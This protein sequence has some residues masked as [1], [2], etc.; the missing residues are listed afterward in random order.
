MPPLSAWSRESCAGEPPTGWRWDCSLAPAQRVYLPAWQPQH[1]WDF[2]EMWHVKC[3]SFQKVWTFQAVLL[4]L[5][6]KCCLLI[7]TCA[8]QQRCSQTPGELI[9]GLQV[10]CV[11]LKVTWRKLHSLRVETSLSPIWLHGTLIPNNT[12]H[13]FQFPQI[14]CAWLRELS[15]CPAD[16]WEERVTWPGMLLRLLQTVALCPGQL[17]LW[18]LEYGCS[19]FVEV[20]VCDPQRTANGEQYENVLRWQ[21]WEHVHLIAEHELGS[22]P[23]I[24]AAFVCCSCDHRHT[25]RADGCMCVLCTWRKIKMLQL[26]KLYFCLQRRF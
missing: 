10:R 21:W 6:I 7:H 18:I 26:S 16:W 25:H 9:T 3:D 22:H 1:A 4:L 12:A 15:T 8:P 17:P 5:Y 19:V 2:G 24:I 11:V 14:T 20:R 13:R 23:H